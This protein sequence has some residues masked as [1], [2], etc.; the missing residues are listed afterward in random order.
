MN[1]SFFS[2]LWI[3]RSS[4]LSNL[5][6]ADV[7]KALVILLITKSSSTYT[8]LLLLLGQTRRFFLTLVRALVDSTVSSSLL[9]LSSLLSDPV[10]SPLPWTKSRPGLFHNRDW[11]WLTIRFCN[12]RDGIINYFDRLFT[13]R[14]PSSGGIIS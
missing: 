11:S 1:S 3:S 6:S 12:F 10:F 9:V 13:V 7:Q 2:P 5:Q 8:I 14:F 4:S